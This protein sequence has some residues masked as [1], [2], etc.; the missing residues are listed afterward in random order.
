M[1]LRVDE[2]ATRFDEAYWSKD[3]AAQP[4]LLIDEATQAIN[5][6]LH[7][8][9]SGSV[10]DERDVAAARVALG[11]LFGGLGQLAALL[12]TSVVKFA[13]SGLREVG[14]LEDQLQTLRVMALCVQQAAEA[15]QLERARNPSNQRHRDDLALPG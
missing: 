4:V 14:P 12:P 11:D 5:E 10:L 2:A 6:A 15:P 9:R 3:N 1:A 8:I 13:E 7:R